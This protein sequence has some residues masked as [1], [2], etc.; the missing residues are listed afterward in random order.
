MRIPLAERAL[1]TSVGDGAYAALR[2]AIVTAQLAPG[3][4]L[5]EN[6][7]AGLIGVSRTP[8]RE[9]LLRL[10]DERLVEVVPQLGTFVTFIDD[11]AVA[12]A[13]FV[14][15]ALEVTPLRPAPSEPDP[16]ALL[17]LRGTL[18]AQER[19]AAAGDDEGFARLDDELH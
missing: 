1:G 7:L 3:R 2:T 4:Q 17:A 14:R 11:D 5:S 19:T 8:V 6:E 9:A 16:S 10:R 15:E 18:D 13:H 12:D